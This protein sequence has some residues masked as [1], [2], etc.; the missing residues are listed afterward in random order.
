MI[1]LKNRAVG[2]RRRTSE[3]IRRGS[4][5][6]RCPVPCRSIGWSEDGILG[7]EK[8]KLREVK[9]GRHEKGKGRK[10]ETDDEFT[11]SDGEAKMRRFDMKVE[12]VR[13]MMMVPHH[14]ARDGGCKTER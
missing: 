4:K 14:R 10:S 1:N 9:I 13:G 6:S 5:K 8:G 12:R 11:T 2:Y 3:T 7:P